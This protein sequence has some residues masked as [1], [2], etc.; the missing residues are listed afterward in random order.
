M[1]TVFALIALTLTATASCTAANPNFC[2]ADTP[3]MDPR[4]SYCDLVSSRCI[5]P[6]EGLCDGDEM[7]TVTSPI[8]DSTTRMCRACAEGSAG[9]GECVAKDEGRPACVRGQCVACE[10]DSDCH[11]SSPICDVTANTCGPC[12]DDAAG[13]AVC[14]ARD[15]SFPFCSV[16]GGCIECEASTSC[17]GE[18]PICEQSTGRCRGCASHDE[19][20]S[21][22]C[23]ESGACLSPDDIIYVDDAIGTDSVGCGAQPSP[24]KT[25]GGELGGV[26][27][28]DAIRT[29]V[30]VRMGNYIDSIVIDSGNTMTIVGPARVDSPSFRAALRVEGGS[31]VTVEGFVLTSANIGLEYHDDFD[32]AFCEGTGSELHLKN[33]DLSNNGGQGVE[34]VGCTIRIDRSRLNSNLG[35]A[36]SVTDGELHL[37]RSTLSWNEG[38]AVNVVDSNFTIVNNFMVK[39]GDYEF[40]S[41]LVGGVSIH[42]VRAQSPQAFA[43]NTVADTKAGALAIAAVVYCQTSSPTVATGNIL[44]FREDGLSTVAGSN[45]AWIYSNIQG[46]HVGE[47][48]IDVDPQFV[49]LDRQD[50]HLKSGSPSQNAA[51]PAA[52]VTVDIDGETR[53]Q[54]GRSDMGA[55]EVPE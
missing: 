36:V 4:R 8:C 21:E 30:K 43:F 29:T 18:T 10:A 33:C 50:L 55:D 52:T 37:E 1:R 40:D 32:G 26:V 5:E 27:K 45:C 28:A 48:N 46:G 25:I 19:C 17:G 54:G 2:N 14:A 49:D 42:N 41:T 44:Y 38:G 9:R 31:K 16:L 20:P 6:P 23:G 7:C 13:D 12:S 47:G 15:A 51:D 24:C 39:N 3:C 22:V 53:P 34:S 11:V 35:V